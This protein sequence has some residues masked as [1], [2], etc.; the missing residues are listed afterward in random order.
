MENELSRVVDALPGLVWTALPDGQID[1]LNQYWREFTGQCIDEASGRGWLAAVHP[2]DVPELNERWQSML[3]A[4]RSGEMEMRLR[5]FDGD[6]RWFLLRAAPLADASGQIIKWCGVNTEI[7]EHRRAQETSHARWWLW[8]PA[9]EQHFRAVVDDLPAHAIHLTPAGKIDYVNRQVLEYFGATHGEMQGREL[10]DLVHP[11]DLP[12]ITATFRKATETGRFDDVE[13][14]LRRVD[15]VYRWFRTRGF[16]LQDAQDRIV[17]WYLLRSDVDDRKRAEALLSGEK[18]LLEMVASGQAMPEILKALCQLVE[19]TTAG[20]YCSVVLVDST[21]THLEYGAAPSLPV[22]F[23]TSI[24]DRPVNADSGPCAMA[25]YSKNQV[26]SSDLTAEMRWAAYQ[27]CPMALA[28]GLQAC[29]STPIPSTTG[30]VLGAI[31]IYYDQPRTPTAQDQDLIDQ[32]THI[33]SIAIERTQSQASLTGALDELIR[34]ER[35]LRTIIDTIPASVWYARADGCGEFWNKRWQDY[36]G[37]A[38]AETYDDWTVIVHPDDLKALDDAVRA[39]LA[40]G[41]PG[42]VESRLRRFDGEY[43]WFLSRWEPLCENGSVINWYGANTD[44]DDAKRA[45]ESLC[46]VRS[47]LAH[48]SRV[49]SLGALTASIAHEVNQPLSGIITNASTCLR[50]LASDPPNVDGARETARRTIRDGH[51]ASDVIARLRALFA[52]RGASSEPVDLNEAT[53]EV[54]ALSLSELQRSRVVLQ[55]YLDDT[56]MPVTGDRV[57]LQQ[58]ILNL[59]MNASDAMRDIE[60]RPRQLVIRT[61]ADEDDHVS[62]TMQDSGVGFEP[63]RADRL[64]DAFYTTKSTGM[65]IGLSVSRSIIENHRGRLWA[66]SNDG[67]GATFSFSIPRSP[68]DVMEDMAGAHAPGTIRSPAAERATH[69]MGNP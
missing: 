30:K 21:G 61:A 43:R 35:R 22:S 7:E 23:I 18:R 52:K 46:K 38:P 15:G 57:Q 58:V 31:A 49:T 34:S 65:G 51:R 68:Y 63:E 2:D 62:L 59:L 27:W 25:V 41:Q 19:S 26:L 1:F 5:R 47:E 14:R 56:L 36:A 64:F 42:Q 53:R 17:L 69:A 4:G 29:W 12:A 67:P 50:M 60:D 44:I 28:H 6:Y 10:G 48:V 54:I 32:V 37:F 16:P 8:P 13:S 3:V 40:S 39:S 45:E 55:T 20:C 66:Q 33:A 24:I 11:D 9:R